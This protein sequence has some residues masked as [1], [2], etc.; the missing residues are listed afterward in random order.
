MPTAVG[1]HS[2]QAR[3]YAVYMD[4]SLRWNDKTLSTKSNE[5][6][7]FDRRGKK[8]AELRQ[9]EQK[10]LQEYS[11]VTFAGI[12]RVLCCS[13]LIILFMITFSP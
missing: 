4:S 6:Q 11:I 10:N 9:K 5:N 7:R 3:F 2:N 1:I 13:A 12:L 8:D